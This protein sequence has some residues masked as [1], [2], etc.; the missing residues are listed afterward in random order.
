MIRKATEREVQEIVDFVINKM[1]DSELKGQL[2]RIYGDANAVKM[3]I[4]QN[5][6]IIHFYKEEDNIVGIISGISNKLSNPK[7]DSWSIALM[8]VLPEYRNQKV[9]SQLL[10][11][12]EQDAKEMGSY[13]INTTVM[14]EDI[15]TQILFI[16]RKYRQEGYIEHGRE[17]GADV[18]YYGKSL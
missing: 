11:A 4:A 18:V 9:G 15:R 17:K 3:R 12:F 5:I 2:Q 16:S 14:S 7:N 13:K 6:E 8:H 1:E 10:D